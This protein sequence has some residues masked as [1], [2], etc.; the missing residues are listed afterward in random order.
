MCLAVASATASCRRSYDGKPG[1]QCGEDAWRPGGVRDEGNPE[2]FI[3]ADVDVG[4]ITQIG[5]ETFA[6]QY[7]AVQQDGAQ[8]VMGLNIAASGHFFELFVSPDYF[9][10]AHISVFKSGVGNPCPQPSVDTLKYFVVPRYLVLEL[11]F[12]DCPYKAC[13]LC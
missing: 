4:I 9:C 11:E 2:H 13:Y 1:K 3:P 8:E 10:L 7:F 5:S 6:P 12:S